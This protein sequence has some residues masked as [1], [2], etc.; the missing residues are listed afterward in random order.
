MYW[1]KTATISKSNSA[2]VFSPA[3]GFAAVYHF[4]TASAFTDATGNGNTGT[5][6]GTVDSLCQIGRG[7]YLN[8]AGY[9]STPDNATL[10]PATVSIS[11]WVKRDGNPV[12]WAKL[13]S[14]GQQAAPY[15]S[16]S[17]EMRNTPDK[18]GFQVAKTDGTVKSVESAS[19]ISNATWSLITGSFN[20]S[21]GSGKLYVNGALLG[22]FTQTGAIEYYTATT[23][24]AVDPFDWTVFMS[25]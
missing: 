9:I 18:V 10:E 24:P 2:A 20:T 1:G 15:A 19:T 6:T 8:G 3:K 5:N 25:T 4:N 23:Y 7:R 11:A 16:Y 17:L 22:S 12:Q 13:V 21:N 14:K